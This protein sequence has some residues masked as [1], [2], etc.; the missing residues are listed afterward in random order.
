MF[1]VNEFIA[2]NW[3]TMT[4]YELALAITEAGHPISKDAVAKRRQN[5]GL[6]KPANGVVRS[7]GVKPETQLSVEEQVSADSELTR[8]QDELVRLRKLYKH[9]TRERAMDADLLSAI[10]EVV[11]TRDAVPVPKPVKVNGD[12]EEE[13]AVLLLGDLH[14]GEVVDEEETGGISVFDTD[15]AYR[16]LM[17]TVEN[18]VRIVKEK[19]RGGYSIKHLEVFGLGDF[20]SG[21]IHKELEVTNEQ[22]I[23]EQVMTAAEFLAE[24][25]QLLCQHFETVTF[26]GVVGNHGRVEMHKYFKMKAKNNYDRMVYLIV[27]KM[28]KNQPNLTMNIPSAFWVVRQVENKGFFL[29]HGDNVKSWMGFPFY[30]VNRGYLKLRTLLKGYD[31]DF[32]TM[33]LGHF[34]NPNIFTVQRDEVIVNG[35]LKGG[36]EFALGAISAA[37][38]P[39]QI[40]FGVH[41]RRGRTWTYYLNSSEVR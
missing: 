30:G 20:V 34:H 18:A 12:V 8:L 29:M 39:I 26:T 33:I 27:E 32:D 40:L 2:S 7:A 41:P 15:I 19:L 6:K 9:A 16:R 31:Q 22:G 37:C 38:D 23:V 5:L 10:H 11:P 3:E 35:S 28:L 24:A 25:L 36:D 14:I 4:D 13:T 1:N 17:F 21:I